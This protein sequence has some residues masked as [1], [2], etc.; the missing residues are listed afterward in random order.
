MRNGE[1]VTIA[2]ILGSG[3]SASDGTGPTTS[4][5]MAGVWS[6]ES[7][8]LQD[9]HGTACTGS[10]TAMTLTQHGVTF[11]GQIEGGT[12]TCTTSGSSSSS[13]FGFGTVSAG[14]IVGDSVHFNVDGTSWRSWG[15]FVNDDS[16][17]GQLNAIYVYQG[18][19]LILTGVWS[20]RPS[21]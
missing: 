13:N 3:C 20:S 4:H 5:K 2:C 10:G 21:P 18:T 15:A 6:Y 7:R 17:A 14:S 9:G 16:M 12:L 1:L 8:G 19:Q 11:T